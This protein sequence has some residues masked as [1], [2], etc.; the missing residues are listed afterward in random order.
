MSPVT[1]KQIIDVSNPM[2]PQ[3]IADLEHHMMKPTILKTIIHGTSL[4]IGYDDY[5]LSIGGIAIYDVSDPACPQFTSYLLFG[6]DCSDI[7]VHGNYA[8]VTASTEGIK[9]IQL[10]E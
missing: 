2:N 10:R 8:Y 4:Y 9:V 3:Y 6:S 1:P 5:G 7:T